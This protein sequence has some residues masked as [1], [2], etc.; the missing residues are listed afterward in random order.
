MPRRFT[1][2]LAAMALV[3]AAALIAGCGASS[4]SGN[5]VASKSPSEILAATK[6][7]T[8]GASSVHVAGALSSGGTPLTLDM[9]LVSGRGGRG[10]IS[11]NGLSFELIVVG[12]TVYIK[13]SPAFYSHFGGAAAA[14]LFQGKWL[15]AP[16][17]SGELASLASLTNLSRLLDQALA[18]HGTL[19]K[20]AT[21]TIA[22]QPVVEL[23]G[24]TNTGSLYIATTGQPYPIE[25]VKRG[26]ETGH[27]SFTRWNDPVSLTAPSG[28]I[29]L[30]QLQH[31]G[32]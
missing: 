2:R 30:S 23:R 9:D 13:G 20:G 21:T 16:V 32:H 19:A 10:Q 24:A 18:S 15:Q 1:P 26:S 22:G 28:A 25:V 8:A 3:L 17:S 31:A 5:G 7:A 27:V 14:Q 6:T 12:D 29:D 11:E 4:S